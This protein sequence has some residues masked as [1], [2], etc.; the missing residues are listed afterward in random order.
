MTSQLLAQ[1]TLPSG[2]VVQ[3]R[4][5]DLTKEDVDAIVNP[6]NE[7]LK[8]GGGAAGA[9]SRAIGREFQEA[10]DAFVEE[11][12]E[13]DVGGQPHV[14]QIQEGTPVPFKMVISAVGPCIYTCVP[15]EMM[16]E[17]L[18]PTMEHCHELFSAA[19]SSFEVASSEGAKSL[20]MPAISS[21]IFGFPKD[22]C[23]EIL[24][25]AAMEFAAD[26]SQPSSL[27]EIRFTNYDQ[28][29]CDIFLAEM[30]RVKAANNLGE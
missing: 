29:T 13:L 28:T 8:N 19:L 9:I 23:A 27:R 3:V 30:A 24:V 15:G 4:K 7:K 11:F 5:G 17:D 20:S 18:Q 10:C 16:E 6:A 14:Y 22:R 12:G 26:V 2:H 25:Q 21:G 1:M